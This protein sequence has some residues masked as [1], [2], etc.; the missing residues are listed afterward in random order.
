MY[1]VLVPFNRDTS[2][3][4]SALKIDVEGAEIRV[5]KDAR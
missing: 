3:P 4:Q 5:L 1:Q 2:T